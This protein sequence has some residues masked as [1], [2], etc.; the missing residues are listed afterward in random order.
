MY[1][2]DLAHY[3]S[4]QL[5]PNAYFEQLNGLTDEWIFSRTGIKTR[6]RAPEGE[7][8][9]T[10]AIR[11][12]EGLKTTDFSDIDLVVGSSYSPFDTVYSHAHAVQRSFA[13][14]NAQVLSLTSAC[15]SFINALEVVQG[16]FAM[17]KAKKAIVVASEHNSYYGHDD[18]EKSGHLWGDGAFAC[19][20]TG[21]DEPMDAPEITDIY[22]KGLGHIGAANESVYLYPKTEGLKMPNGRDVF[23]F[24]TTYMEEAL[25]ELMK[26]NHYDLTDLNYIIPHQANNRIITNL[27]SR[28]KLPVEKVFTNIEKY[29]NTGSASTG[30]CLSENFDTIEKGSLVG[31]TVFGGGYSCGSML[32]QF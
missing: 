12:V 26:R 30:I 27:A 23:I 22:T 1:I 3:V 14:V 2:T 32:V 20:I 4:D 9:N 8:T 17:G 10:M 5:L 31:F 13:I 6:S 7:T 28:M 21:C 19:I 24:A 16:Y 11:A 25:I 29:G 18:C 15:S